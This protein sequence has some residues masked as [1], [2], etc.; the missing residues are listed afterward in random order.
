MQPCQRFGRLSLGQPCPFWYGIQQAKLPSGFRLIVPCTSASEVQL[1]QRQ[2]FP[3]L[4]SLHSLQDNEPKPEGNFACWMPYQK[5]Q[6]AKTE[7]A[8]ALARLHNN[9]G[10]PQR[11]L[12]LGKPEQVTQTASSVWPGTCLR[13]GTCA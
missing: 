11:L 1:R 2:P 5:G 10:A 13:I 12:R 8:E 9:V 3:K 6:A 7:A 4:T